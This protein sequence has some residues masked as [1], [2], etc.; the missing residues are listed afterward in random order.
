MNL[1]EYQA[2]RLFAKFNLPILSGWV[3]SSVFD[4]ERFIEKIT[5]NPPWIIKCQIHA[6]GRGKSGGVCIAHAPQDIL[7]FANQWFSKRLITSQTTDCGEIV[8][9]ILIEPAVNIIREL[10]F[11]ILIDRD[12]SQIICVVS[13]K[14]GV[15]IEKLAHESPDLLFQITI[16]PEIGA[17]PYQGRIIAYKLGLIGDQINRFSKIFI[18]IVRMFLETDLMLVEINPLAITDNHNLMCLD[19]KVVFDHNALFRQSEFLSEFSENNRINPDFDF[20]ILNV[21]YVALNGDIGCMVNGAGLAM[22]TMD[23]MQELGGMPANFLDIGGD[24][25]KSSIIS[26]LKALLKNEQV[27]AILV[28]IFGGIVCCNL[29]ADSVITA[30]SEC[31]N[32]IPI[33]IRLEGNNAILGINKLINSHLNIIVINNLIYAIQRVI[34]LVK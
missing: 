33:V 14:G 25:N 17:Y 22:A 21:N 16:D 28:N 1:Y 8:N 32:R 23:L 7:S 34:E 27:K 3:C 18:N 29:V 30:V 2:K 11:S 24:T 19:A 5:S 15:D 31:G 20:N 9:H 6:G 4:V 26:A 12:T 10:Y 13:I